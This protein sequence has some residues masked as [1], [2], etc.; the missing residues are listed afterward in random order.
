MTQLNRR[1]VLTGGAAV[2]IAALTVTAI[3]AFVKI[4]S[5]THGRL[6]KQREA[7]VYGG[8]ERHLKATLGS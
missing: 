1:A 7:K 8:Q 6:L 5:V 2:G 4:Y 3:P